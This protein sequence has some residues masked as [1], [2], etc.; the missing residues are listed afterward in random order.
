MA[1]GMYGWYVVYGIWLVAGMVKWLICLDASGWYQSG[2]VG[3]PAWL[4]LAGMVVYGCSGLVGLVDKR[5]WS[6]RSGFLVAPES[7]D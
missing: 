3:E 4:Y 6:G 2:P 1:Y 7:P 5:L